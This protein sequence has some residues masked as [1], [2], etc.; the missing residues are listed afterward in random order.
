MECLTADFSRFCITTVKIYFLKRRLSTLPSASIIWRISVKCSNTLS[1]IHGD[2][3][4]VSFY[5]WG[6]EIVLKFPK[7]L[8]IF[9]YVCEKIFSSVLTSLKIH[10]GF[11]KDQVSVKKYEKLY[12]KT[13]LFQFKRFLLSNLYLTLKFKITLFKICQICPK[14]EFQE[15]INLFKVKNISKI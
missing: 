9:F 2:N 3:N 1:D 7:I 15:W 14:Y 11:K 10:R 13:A 12:I 8:Q 4:P 5:L 6:N